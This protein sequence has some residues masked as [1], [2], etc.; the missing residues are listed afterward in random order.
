RRWARVGCADG[1]RGDPLESEPDVLERAVCVP[2]GAVL[3]VEVSD[4]ADLNAVRG[5]QLFISAESVSQPSG[6]TSTWRPDVRWK[7]PP[8]MVGSSARVLR[9]AFRWLTR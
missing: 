8:A 1:G 9:L 2:M 5:H 7:R 3:R 4:D 6:Q